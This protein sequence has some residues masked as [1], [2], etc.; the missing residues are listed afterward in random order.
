MANGFLNHS[1]ITLLELHF[2]DSIQPDQESLQM[3]NFTKSSVNSE[4]ENLPRK[5]LSICQMQGR[6]GAD[7]FSSGSF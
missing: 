2:L 6:R 7:D 3:G 1:G 4:L 5:V